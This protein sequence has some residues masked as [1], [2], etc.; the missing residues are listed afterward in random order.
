MSAVAQK[1]VFEDDG[2]VALT[3]IQWL[4][5]H[6]AP[7]ITGAKALCVAM[8]SEAWCSAVHIIQPLPQG[9]H[10]KYVRQHHRRERAVQR[11]AVRWFGSDDVFAFSFC[12]LCGAL[13]LDPGQIRRALAA[14]IGR[15]TAPPFARTGT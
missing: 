9:R 10:S 4:E 8:I 6:R 7:E 2:W 14:E 11:E 12:H 5:L 3:A 1:Q 15:R 13:G